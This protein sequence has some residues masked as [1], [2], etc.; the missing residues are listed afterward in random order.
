M[1]CGPRLREKALI[2]SN[3]KPWTVSLR[4]PAGLALLMG[5]PGAGPAVAGAGIAPGGGFIFLSAGI[6]L[7][8]LTQGANAR[9]LRQAVL[10]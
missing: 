7:V 5:A 4:W 8:R 10:E 2:H 1:P 3:Q 9:I 6:Y